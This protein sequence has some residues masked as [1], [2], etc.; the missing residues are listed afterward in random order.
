MALAERLDDP[1]PRV[2]LLN[3]YA[4]SLVFAGRLEEAERR[5]R[6]SMRLAD[7]SGNPFLRF[8]A[9]VPLTRAFIIAGRPS[10]ALVASEEAEALGRGRP[11]LESEPGLS[12][13][14]LLLVQR[15]RA[16]TYLGR[17]AEGAQTIDRAIAL[18][19][20][21]RERELTAFAEICRVMPCGVMGEPE[22]ELAHAQRALE[23]AE[24]SAN[25]YLRAMSL[26]ALGQ[27]HVAGG[28][29]QE[30]LAALSDVAGAIRANRTAPLVETDTV[31]LLAEA[32][33][34]AG[35]LSAAR[36]SAEAAVAIAQRYRRPLSEI[37]GYLAQARV[38][39][40]DDDG[41]GARAAV[42]AARALVER[43]GAVM[44]TPFLD[45]VVAQM[46]ARRLG[47]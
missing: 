36:A 16:L 47:T 8:V 11:E 29:W 44:V 20:T 45:A 4:N 43:T 19:R 28:R 33:L 1:A 15:G 18:A 3:V 2:R 26:S 30:A 23:A 10:E 27:A 13:Y 37:R 42:A 5:F 34:G 39:A 41:D 9:R 46:V 6:E 35:D 21:R 17:P 12:P 25:T 22:A 32:Q 38:L 14:G 40:A 31:A 7:A 24:S